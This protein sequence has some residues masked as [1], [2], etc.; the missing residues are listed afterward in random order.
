MLRDALKKIDP[1]LF[2]TI[3]RRIWFKNWVVHCKQA[4]NGQAVL[5]YFAP[6]IFRV[7]L[8]NKRIIKLENNHVTFVYKHPKTKQWTPVRLPVFEFLRRFLQHVLPQNFKKVR[9]YGFLNSKYK[10]VLATL[11]YKLGVVE[12]ETETEKSINHQKPCCPICGK[13]MIPIGTFEPDYFKEP[14]QQKPP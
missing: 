8:S 12:I 1:N 7:A 4:G 2:E 14:M 11:K 9:H 3:P 13:E 6:Y 5:K 10:Q